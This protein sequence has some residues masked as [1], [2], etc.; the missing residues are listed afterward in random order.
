MPEINSLAKPKVLVCILCGPERHQWLNPMLVQSLLRVAQD[1]RFDVEMF[2][3]FGV[4]GVDEARNL[5]IDTARQKNVDWCI[6]IDNDVMCENPLGILRDS[7]DSHLDIVAVSYGLVMEH[8]AVAPSVDLTG[9]RL[10]N[11]MRVKAAGA[12]VLMIRRIVWEKLPVLFKGNREDAHL[13]QLA[14]GA[15]FKIWTHASLAGHLHSTDVT[16]GLCGVQTK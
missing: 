12:G 15:G 9:E 6:Q 11:F 3:A 14:Q 8:G 4:H 16:R 1:Q 10:G 13:C 2:F 7:I 5:C